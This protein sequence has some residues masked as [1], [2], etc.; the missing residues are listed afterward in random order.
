M[1]R[2]SVYREID[3]I[4]GIA[5]LT[6]VLEHAFAVKYI[7]LTGIGWCQ[8][9]V[10]IIKS[11][12]MQLFFIMSGFLFANSRQISFKK[13]YK[14]KIDRILVPML[15][16]AFLS[17][18]VAFFF[19]SFLNTEVILSQSL[20]VDWFIYGECNWFLYTI[21]I[22]F[23]IA[24]PLKSKLTTPIVIGVCVLFII[25]KEI[26]LSDVKIFQL[27]HVIYM[28]FFFLLGYLVC[29]YYETLRDFFKKGYI[30]ACSLVLYVIAF[31]FSDISFLKNWILPIAMSTF[32]WGG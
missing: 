5:I 3:I 23:F 2:G 1:E 30:C 32:I 16:F 6:V 10:E 28:M 13:A 15:F 21:L 24:I 27:N 4:K 12:N 19:S 26:G 29:T 31:Q 22:I 17:F 14:S 8:N 11:F 9:T 18:V 25:V 7:D 20:L